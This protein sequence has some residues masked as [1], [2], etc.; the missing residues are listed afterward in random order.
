MRGEWIVDVLNRREEDM[1]SKLRNPIEPLYY[2]TYNQQ[3]CPIKPGVRKYRN[4][5]NYYYFII[6]VRIR[7]TITCHYLLC[8]DFFQRL[9]VDSGV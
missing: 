8:L 1:C 6:Y 5:I 7:G 9:F 4:L 2:Y 3:A